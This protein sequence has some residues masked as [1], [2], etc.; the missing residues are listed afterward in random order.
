MEHDEPLVTAKELKILP[1][2]TAW[3]MAQAGQIPFLRV[4]YR[5]GHLR[6]WAVLAILTYFK[7]VP[8]A[9]LRPPSS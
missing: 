2:G 5:A 7:Y 6:R 8:V 3:R 4:G 9:V 1:P